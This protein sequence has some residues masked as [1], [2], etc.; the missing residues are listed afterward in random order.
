MKIDSADRKILLAA[1]SILLVTAL[2]STLVSPSE[3]ESSPY[4]SPYSTSSGGAKAA[5]SLL[6]QLGY[7]VERWR[8][9]PAKLQEHGVNTVLLVAVPTQNPTADDLANI[10]KYV[11]NGGRLVAIGLNAMPLLPHR[12]LMPG[13]PHF[14]WQNYR[15][16]VPDAITSNAPEIVMAPRVYWRRSDFNS[17]EDFG[18]ADYAVVTSY[19][20][21]K[22]EVIWWAAADPLTN[23][24]II[25]AS[26]LQLLLNSLGPAGERTVLWDDY[27]HEGEV[28][29]AES[30]FNSPLKWSLL[31]L[32]LLAIAVIFTYSRRH[33]PLRA[34]QQ[35][36]RLA[37]LEF[38][39][40][41]GGLYQRVGATELPVQVAYERFRHQLHRKLGIGV[42]TTPQQVVARLQDRL[43]EL[44]TQCEHTL[45]EC[46]SARYEDH[47]GENDSLRLVKSLNRFSEHLKLNSKDEGTK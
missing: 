36:S 34:L 24:G 29:L 22:G 28:T 8:S 31:Q 32:G 1:F 10:R 39:E 14:A 40:T 47:I 6:S 15:A 18:D 7:S 3:D 33:G 30:L 41:L 42:N 45:T 43:G 46:E 13:V 21:G 25:Q 19:K 38:V 9:S 2:V 4:P 37:T 16:L 20:Y 12:E 44:A 5:Y 35:P 26:N 11:Q 17:E 27:F 23:S